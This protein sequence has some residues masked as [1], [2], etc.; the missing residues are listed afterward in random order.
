MPRTVTIPLLA[1]LLLILSAVTAPAFE[2]RE[3]GGLHPMDAFRLLFNPDQIK[4][5]DAVMSQADQEM[6]PLYQELAQER[7]VLR[8]MYKNESVKDQ[9]ITAQVAKICQMESRLAVKHAAFTR[10]VRRIATPEQL[11]KVDGL[12]AQEQMNRRLFFEA[13]GKAHS[14]THGQ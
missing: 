4:Q 12:E 10:A 8:D 11:A 7:Q 5:L 2:A 1:A 9:D 3:E 14:P 6:G 13:L